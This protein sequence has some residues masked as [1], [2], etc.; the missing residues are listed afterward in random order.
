MNNRQ[1]QKV[2]GP[3]TSTA[4][5]ANQLLSLLLYK[6]FYFSSFSW[7]RLSKFVLLQVVVQLAKLF[8]VQV[9]SSLDLLI[10]VL[11]LYNVRVPNKFLILDDDSTTQGCYVGTRNP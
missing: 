5:T 7:I 3:Q 10:Q 2:K 8:H 4:Q 6:D 9:S 1:P 11:R